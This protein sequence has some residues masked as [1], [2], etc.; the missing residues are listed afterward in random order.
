MPR[1]IRTKKN[2]DFIKSDHDLGNLTRTIVMGASTGK[3]H[4]RVTELDND[5]NVVTIIG[6]E[7]GPG[8]SVS[9]TLDATRVW[10]LATGI[11]ALFGGTLLSHD[12]MRVVEA[13]LTDKVR[14]ILC[15]HESRCLD[16]DVDREV[17]LRELVKALIGS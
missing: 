17:V 1:A 7:P 11:A 10:D 9:V 12:Q 15:Q 4:V 3:G 2:E 8:G 6:G 5:L 13:E 14:D 16:D